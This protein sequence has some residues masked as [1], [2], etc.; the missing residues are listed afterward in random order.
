[1]AAGAAQARQST[2][3]KSRAVATARSPVDCRPPTDRPWLARAGDALRRRAVAA[4]RAMSNQG[5]SASVAAAVDWLTSNDHHLGLPPT[6]GDRP[7]AALTAGAIPTLLAVGEVDLARN[8]A[9]WLA[10]QCRPEGGV[11]DHTEEQV[12][13]GASAG[14]LLTTGW[15]LQTWLALYEAGVAEMPPATARAA[16]WL[17]A[18]IDQRGAIDLAGQSPASVDWWGAPALHVCWLPTLRAAARRF[19]TPAWETAAERAANYARRAVDWSCSSRAARVTAQAVAA[20][21]EWGDLDLA[22]HAMRWPAS[23]Q[24]RDGGVPAMPGSL[25]I[26]GAAQALFAS[27]WYQ[28]GERDLADRALGFLQAR[29][30]AEGGFPA[31]WEGRFHR[32]SPGSSGWVAKLFLDA[33]LLQVATAF[34]TR[35]NLPTEIDPADGRL[36]AVHQWFTSLEPSPFV[37]DVGCG[38]GRFLRELGQRFP[39]ARLVGIDPAASYLDMLPPRVERRRGALPRL[40]ARDGEFDAALAIESLE[41]SLLP[42]RAV[43]ELCRVVRP[44]GRLLIID[45]H[46]ARQ[47]LSVRER[48]EEWFLPETVAGWLGRHCRDVRVRPIAHGDHAQP[49]GLFL[50]WEATR[51]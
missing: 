29:Q 47:A 39:A 38:P 48:W 2:R 21:I 3:R 5:G 32:P 8:W 10:S 4:W 18:H 11:L 51:C 12:A 42:E 45:K 22:R 46:R 9:D 41:H 25:T 44:G 49:N 40:P 6:P 30:Q 27:I 23:A 20:W 43:A 13:A 36:T 31:T 37:A 26:D 19:G 28:L 17:A 14:S 7:S 1:M 24:R 33:S 50:C 16:S 15:A 35:P 34:D